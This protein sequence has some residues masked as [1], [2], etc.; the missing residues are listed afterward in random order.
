MSEQNSELV[1]KI[2]QQFDSAP[3]PNIPLDKTPKDD[4]ELLFIHDSVT[5]YYLRNQRVINTEGTII[6]DAGCGSG[7]KSLVL[8]EANP[9]ATIVGIDLSEASVKL[10]EQRLHYYGF[11]NAKFYAMSIADLPQ[12]GLEFDYIN[13]DDVLYLIPDLVNNLI[14]MRSVL[15]PTGIMRG[16]LHSAFQRFNYYRAQQAFQLMGLMDSNPG[17]LEIEVV[18]ETMQAL[19]DTIILKVATWNQNKNRDSQ[20]VILANYLLQGDTGYTIPDMFAALDAAGLEFISMVNWRQWGLLDLF[21]DP[22]NLPLF[23][24]MGLPDLPVPQQLH[25]FELIH[26]IHRLLDFWCGH[27]NQANPA[28]SVANWSESDWQH[29]QVSLHPQLR[30]DK[31]RDTVTNSILKH[32]FF[33][34]SR[35]ITNQTRKPIVVESEIAADLYPLWE[36]PQ[37]LAALAQRSLQIRP[38]NPITLEPRTLEQATQEIQDL[39]TRLEVFLYILLETRP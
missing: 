2:R 14:A 21:E 16:N 27:P 5:P 13:C 23:W 37:S 6:L 17:E 31:I 1:E 19:K 12:L 20:E 34:F 33:E 15:K 25:L 22:E 28:P 32:E 36:G 29:A 3:Y 30:S 9:G 35:Y 7:Y 26:P 10:A 39:L 38:R 4:Y 18:T 11:N 8:A 24:A